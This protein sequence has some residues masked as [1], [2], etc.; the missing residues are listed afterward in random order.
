MTHD[1]EC[2]KKHTNNNFKVSISERNTTFSSFKTIGFGL[3][4]R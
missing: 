1:Q 3:F 4:Q 2:D